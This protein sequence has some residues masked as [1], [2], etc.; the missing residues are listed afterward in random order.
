[1]TGSKRWSEGLQEVPGLAG[2]GAGGD[3]ALDRIARLASQ[4]IGSEAALV[5]LVDGDRQSFP[6]QHGLHAPWR[7]T[8]ETPLLESIWRMVVATGEV[9]QIDDTAADER[10]AGH[11]ART[12]L[13]VGSYLGAPLSDEAGNVLGTLCVINRYPHAWTGDERDLLVDLSAAANSELR[14]RIAPSRGI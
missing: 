11:E 9:V 6:G 13:E 8:R 10:T 7:D 5:A 12:V 14:G 4:V 1:M 3:D 2:V